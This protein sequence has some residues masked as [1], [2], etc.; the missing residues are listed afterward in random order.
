MENFLKANNNEIVEL[1]WKAE[2]TSDAVVKKGL[3]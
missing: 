2:T 3:N 1:V